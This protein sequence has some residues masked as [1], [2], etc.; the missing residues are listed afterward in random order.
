MANR[1]PGGGSAPLAVAAIKPAVAR[2]V[3]AMEKAHRE[4]W[5]AFYPA[6]FVSIPDARIESFYWIQWYKMASATR[7]DR[8]AVD[9]M[10]PSFK[11][12]RW[13]AYW[14]NLNTQHAYYTVQTGNHLE[15]GDRLSR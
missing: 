6:S 13:S 2:G 5:H 11:L 8:P 10:R 15:I 9:L 7:A 14:M 12:S 3:P 4:G 1:I